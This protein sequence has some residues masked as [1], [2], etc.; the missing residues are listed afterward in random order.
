MYK[1]GGVRALEGQGRVKGITKKGRCVFF[2]WTWFGGL[3]QH[4]LS[5]LVH[6]SKNL[7]TQYGVRHTYTVDHGW[8]NICETRFSFNGWPNICET[9]WWVVSHPISWMTIHGWQHH[10]WS[11]ICETPWWV[12]QRVSLALYVGDP[13]WT[14]ITWESFMPVSTIITWEN[15]ITVS[16]S[17]CTN[18]LCLSQRS[19][20][21]WFP[22]LS[23]PS[24]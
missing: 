5:I 8:P 9:R 17:Y 18:L 7:S 4:K 16:R 2:V 13:G 11:N 21:F 6:W 15:L 23:W 14:I 19:H 10:G 3:G 12:A 20:I 1:E 22:S 24:F